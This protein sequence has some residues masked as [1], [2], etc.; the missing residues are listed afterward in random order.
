VL[1]VKPP[2]RNI[3]VDHGSFVTCSVCIWL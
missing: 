3:Q 2:V 1:V